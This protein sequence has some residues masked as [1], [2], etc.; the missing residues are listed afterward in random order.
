MSDRRSSEPVGFLELL[1]DHTR[2]RASAV[3]T[4]DVG[5]F[6]ILIQTETRLLVD[7]RA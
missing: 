7:E 1:E 2:V 3:R 4:L 6:D 5:F